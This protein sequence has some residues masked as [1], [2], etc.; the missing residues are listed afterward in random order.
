MNIYRKLLLSVIVSILFCTGNLNVAAQESS[1][2]DVYRLIEN[3]D[4]DD[5]LRYEA[6]IDSLSAIGLPAVPILLK[7][8]ESDPE[9]H[10]GVSGHSAFTNPEAPAD[11]APRQSIE[12]R[13]FAFFE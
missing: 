2:E 3:L 7:T 5:E 10:G 4:T 1:E 6:A 9:N 13:A 8:F 12:T 11:A